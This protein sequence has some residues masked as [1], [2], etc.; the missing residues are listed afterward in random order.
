MRIIH[1]V[2]AEAH[3]KQ[4][5]AEVKVDKVMNQLKLAYT[6]M[7][8]L[9]S[10]YTDVL[11]CRCPAKNY[12]LFLLERYLQL[13]IKAFRAGKSIELRTINDLISCFK[14]Y[15]DKVQRL[16]CEFYLH[17]LILEKDCESNPS[18]FIGDF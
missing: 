18:P 17:N 14:L 7:D 16:L 8:T 11:A 2:E 3:E 9:Y 6:R 12:A 15:G 1:E 4:W 5:K 10:L 13:K